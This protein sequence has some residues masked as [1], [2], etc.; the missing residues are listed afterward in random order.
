MTTYT[1]SKT[2]DEPEPWSVRADLA[3]EIISR[4]EKRRHAI[5]AARRYIEG[6]WRH[7]RKAGRVVVIND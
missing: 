6:D 5:D 4:H 7:S 1:V 2:E 3:R